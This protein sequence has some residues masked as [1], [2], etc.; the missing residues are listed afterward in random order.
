MRKSQNHIKLSQLR[1]LA[2]V[3]AC[4]NFS[5]AAL[6]LE[7]SQS[8]VSHAIAALESALGVMLFSRGRHGATLTPVGK[9]VLMY[10]QQILHALEELAH[11][12]NLAKGLQGGQVRIASFRSVTTHLLPRIM[13]KFRQ[14]YPAIAVSIVEYDD[15]PSIDE[16]L[17][18]GQAD[19]GFTHLPTS[20]EFETWELLKDEYVV[21]IPHS[22]KPKSADLSWNQLGKYPLVMALD[23][24]TCDQ[25]VYAHCL[26]Y[27]ETLH[28]AYQFRADSTI[29]GMVAQGLGVTIIPRLAAEP[30]PIG[31]QVYRL[32]VPLYRKIGVA[33]LKDALLTPATFAFLELLRGSMSAKRNPEKTDLT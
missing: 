4:S 5:E 24:D 11:D 22:L 23:G 1:V 17:R 7:M 2:A 15:S 31:L 27:G 16:D 25:Q 12:V 6:E 14:Q 28:V 19:L 30:I 32:P 3:A 8:A 13:A 20:D 9:R 29:V 33:V 21:L 26:Q 10:A 18:R